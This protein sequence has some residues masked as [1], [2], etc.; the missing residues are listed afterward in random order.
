MKAWSILRSRP[1]FT[2]F[3]ESSFSNRITSVQLTNEIQPEMKVSH[4]FVKFGQRKISR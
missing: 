4:I 1:R 2:V 3:Y